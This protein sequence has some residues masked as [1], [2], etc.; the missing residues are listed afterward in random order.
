VAER[1]TRSAALALGALLCLC[2]AL[3]LAQE[4][5]AAP[6]QIGQAGKDVVWVPTP[7]RLI[8]R[9]LQMA[10]TASSDL[11]VDLG[12]GDGR[13]PIAAAKNFGARGL[14]IEYDAN[15]VEL[16]IRSAARE[17]VAGR[18]Q[19]LRQDLFQS[20]LS[21]ATVIALYVSPT[22]MLQ[23]KPRLLAL[24]AGTRVVSHQFTLGDWEPDEQAVAEGRS[25]YLW[26]VPARVEGA[27]RLSLGGDTYDLRLQQAHQMLRGTA[28][29]GARQSPVFAA[30]L[31]GEAVRFAFVDRNGDPRSF[32]GRVAGDAME[33]TSSTPGQ[34]DL[35]WSARRQKQ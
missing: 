13:I 1:L 32:M 27:W 10:D 25:A 12:S 16:S 15:L 24:K 35:A 33:G 26:I 17:G 2:A 9:M 6:P 31:R 23:L 19:F 29:I 34:P 30:R 21:A 22:V 3:S 4:G 11:V 14:G 7:D 5:K 20:D 18:V 8:V 28:E